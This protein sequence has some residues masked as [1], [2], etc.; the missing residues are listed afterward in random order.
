MSPDNRSAMPITSPPSTRPS[1][2]NVPSS[3]Y[4]AVSR[5]YPGSTQPLPSLPVVDQDDP[6]MTQQVTSHCVAS[7]NPE[8]RRLIRSYPA[9][10]QPATSHYPAST[11]P[12]P[13][14]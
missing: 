14:R 10:D 2:S 5:Q 8:A 12:L 6:V 4:P 13:T 1:H 9:S 7:F 11:P 3:R